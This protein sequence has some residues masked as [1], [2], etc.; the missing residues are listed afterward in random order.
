MLILAFFNYYLSPIMHRAFYFLST[1]LIFSLLLS[2]VMA[3]RLTPSTKTDLKKFIEKQMKK[4]KIQGVSIALVDGQKILWSEGF[5]LMDVEKGIS[6]TEKTIYRVG[7]ISKLFVAT[8]IMQLHEQGKLDI[9]ESVQKYLP[10][11]KPKSRFGK[12]NNITVRQLL[13]HHSGLPSDVFDRFFAK[14]VPPFQSIV[15][16]LNEEYVCTEAETVWSYSNAAYS[17]LGVIIER[18]SGQDF[19]QYTDDMLSKMDMDLSS[20]EVNSTME[21]YFSK[22]YDRKGKLLDEGFIRDVPAGMLHSNVLDMSNFIMTV[23]NDGK[24]RNKKLLKSATL[25]EMHRPQNDDIALDFS[26]SIGLC[27]F[28]NGNWDYA[29]GM[30]EHGGDTRTFH[31]QMSVLPKQNMGVVVLTNSEGGGAGCRY[32]HNEIVEKALID[33]RDLK[34]PKNE[35]AEKIKLNKKPSVQLLKKYKGTYAIGPMLADLKIKKNKWLE[36]KVAGIKIQLVPNSNKTF[37]PRYAIG[38]LRFPQK[39]QQIILDKVGDYE[40]LKQVENEDT[41]LFAQKIFKVAPNKT[42]KKRLGFY[43]PLEEA[44]NELF[45]S[46]ELAEENN[47]LVLKVM[48]I[49]ETQA[50]AM[51]LNPVSNKDAVMYG[52]GRNT[53]NTIRVYE[54]NGQE[55]LRYSGIELVRKE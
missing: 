9:D 53:G 31:A 43:E 4:R 41:T 50:V 25:K 36:A 52:L 5:G 37:T 2:P 1:I 8:A 17:T 6:A 35:S 20:F 28:V 51:G 44:N 45:K 11:F 16:Y 24:Y 19:I 23:L 33:L 15:D 27:W 30:V 29:G 13:T 3:Q 18:V 38:F 10:E 40:I 26:E 14:E 54:K 22:G 12:T 49:D 55:I 21:Q 34:R 39:T 48:F 42:W 32:I 47:A 46:F 7:S